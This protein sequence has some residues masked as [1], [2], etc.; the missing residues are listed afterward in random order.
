MTRLLL[1]ALF[2]LRLGAEQKDED[3]PKVLWRDPGQKT[4]QDW[5]CGPGGCDRTP[6][7]PY[8]FTKEELTGTNPK[9]LVRDA[10]DQ[11][12]S[13]KLG[14]EALPEC[15]APRFVTAIGYGAEPT[16]F[17]ASGKIE[18]LGKLQRARWIMHKDGTFTK[19]RFELRGQKDFVFLE[20]HAWAWDDNPFR[21]THELAGLKIVMMLLTNWD[22]KDAHEGDDSNNSV[23]RV[24]ADGTPMLLHAVSDWGASLGR[25]GGPQ[26][27]DRSDCA[28]FA[29]DTPHFVEGVR[30]NEVLFG[31]H[32]KHEADIKN[33]ITVEDVRWLL[34]HLSNVTPENLKAGLKAAGATDRQTTCWSHSIEERIRELQA[35]SAKPRLP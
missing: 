24:P 18:G 12:W 14:G 13:V 7:P 23:F 31:F 35:V 34:P 27:R 30:Q 22:A 29:I 4:M 21:G 6:T 20:H 26:R 16:Y 17:V 11:T 9:V 28:G 25:W 32:G 8:Q 19:G 1:S 33:N 5:I 15:F 2:V 10:K 3:L